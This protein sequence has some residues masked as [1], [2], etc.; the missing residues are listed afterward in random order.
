MITDPH[1]Q[2]IFV[3][4]LY[5]T[6]INLSVR[7]LCFY[8][9]RKTERRDQSTVKRARSTQ[10][11]KREWGANNKNIKDRLCKYLEETTPAY[12]LLLR[13]SWGCGKTF[14]VK[15][16]KDEENGKIGNIWYISLFG[17]R[18][19]DEI[20]DKIF[21]AA[22]PVFSAEKTQGMLS[23]GYSILKTV[24]KYK[25]D[26][27]I[28][29][30]GIKVKNLFRQN[31]ENLSCRLLIVD[32]IER[33]DISIKELFGYFSMLLGDGV[34]IVLVADEDRIAD[35]DR[36]YYYDYK[37]KIIGETYE[38]LP[39]YNAAIQMVLNNLEGCCN[40]ELETLIFSTITILKYRNLRVIQQILFQWMVLFKN[41]DEVYRKDVETLRELFESYLVLQIQYKQNILKVEDPGVFMEE[42]Q[43]AWI[44]YKVY[45]SPL[46]EYRKNLKKQ[47]EKK[48]S[49]RMNTI[50][51]QLPILESWYELLILGKMI[52]VEWMNQQVD[53][54]YQKKK[55]RREREES[56]K[57]PL[58]QMSRLVMNQD[59]RN[60]EHVKA[61]F[62]ELNRSFSE[63]RYIYVDDIM[64][65]ICICI[66]LIEDEALPKE[67]S[68]KW[69]GDIL[70]K[71]IE[72]HGER[73]VFRDL[74]DE[75]VQK[76]N[77]IEDNRLQRIIDRIFKLALEKN[78]QKR[79][80]D[81]SNKEDFFRLIEVPDNAI[82]SH[83]SKPFLNQ[84]NLPTLFT[85]LESDTT[86]KRHKELLMFLEYRYGKVITNS[87]LSVVDYEDLK[88]VEELKKL[89]EKEI[90]RQKHSYSVVIGAYK[91][92]LH[93][94]EDLLLYM[95]ACKEE[96]SKKK[97][98]NEEFDLTP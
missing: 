45:E 57:V 85:W 35:L 66:K 88:A 90:N 51:Y 30:L 7:N 84:L 28:G 81:F 76:V 17:V 3:L 11:V 78:E 31:G 96:K 63:G 59:S 50:L 21:E 94:Y 32:D 41:L 37:E 23:V 62:K 89:Y 48:S 6:T 64:G 74:K 15:S 5:S 87:P 16:F 55:I 34:R 46:T 97:V 43:E 83:M 77:P 44:A 71:F 98:D 40:K 1:V 20:N 13:G 93:K 79:M 26:I 39:E 29:D 56:K 60:R 92:I 24:S 22:Y 42:C 27:D 9:D 82:N 67:Y 65:Y 10:L 4:W 38:V 2:A 72:E 80:M 18:S 73:I 8:L 68:Y 70:Q 54:I 69:L 49:Y 52:D 75:F 95:K 47:E 25:L 19:L 86:M 12:A 53:R 58:Y 36:Q 61:L 14:L 33:S 91:N